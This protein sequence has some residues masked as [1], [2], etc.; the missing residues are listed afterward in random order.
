MSFYRILK[1][2]RILDSKIPLSFPTLCSEDIFF[3]DCVFVCVSW[4]SVFMVHVKYISFLSLFAFSPS[5]A[6]ILEDIIGPSINKKTQNFRRTLWNVFINLQLILLQETNESWPWRVHCILC[7]E[8]SWKKSL[9][10]DD[11]SQPWGKLLLARELLPWPAQWI[12][13]TWNISLMHR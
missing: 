10:L 3:G 6:N 12:C 7:W 13:N 9:L 1:Y 4:P 11:H 8:R 2:K 5:S